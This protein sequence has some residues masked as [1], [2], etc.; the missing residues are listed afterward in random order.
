MTP[1]LDEG[2]I[3][4]PVKLQGHRLSDPIRIFWFRCKWYRLNQTDPKSVSEKIDFQLQSIGWTRFQFLE[5][6][7]NPS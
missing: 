6:F 4:M 7:P 3:M 2:C 5:A 1:A